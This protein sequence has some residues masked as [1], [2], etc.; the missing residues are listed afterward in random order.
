MMH[1]VQ[2]GECLAS[3][4]A[5]YGHAWK[6]VWNHPENKQLRDARK[7]PNVLHPGDA[8]FVPDKALKAEPAV[9]NK[10][11]QFKVHLE[12]SKLHLRL[13]GAFQSLEGEPFVIELGGERIEGKTDSDGKLEAEIPAGLTEVTLLLP[14]RRQSYTLS[15][16]HLDPSDVARGA[17]ERLRNLGMLSSD[18]PDDVSLGAALSM[19]QRVKKLEETG[20]LDDRTAAALRDE[21]GC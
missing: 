3:I 7:D 18:H 9:T 13:T 17:E 6:T 14:K 5:R 16:G 15:L 19:F 21:H 4:A 2:Q 10:R 11:H 1:R 8:V 12:K 20:A